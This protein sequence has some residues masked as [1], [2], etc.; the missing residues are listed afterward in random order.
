MRRWSSL[1]LGSLCL[2]LTSAAASPR[3]G[4]LT[5]GKPAVT[6]YDYRSSYVLRGLCDPADPK[7][8]ND[9]RFLLTALRELES[10][11]SHPLASALQAFADEQLA[12]LPATASTGTFFSAG[13]SEEIVG[14]GLKAVVTSSVAGQSPV[15]FEVCVG[16]EA[17][18]TTVGAA[19]ATG[20][21]IQQWKEGA[22]SVVLLAAK[23]LTMSGDTGQ[24]GTYEVCAS[25]AVADPLRPEAAETIAKLRKAGKEVWLCSGDNPVTARAVARQ[26]TSP[27]SALSPTT[28]ADQVFLM[29]LVGI[30]DDCVIA[31]V[32]PE[33]KAE[34]INKLKGMPA[35]VKGST[36]GRFI[37]MAGDGTNDAVA[38]AAADVGFVNL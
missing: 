9:R 2:A 29:R 10:Q 12:L 4:T 18:M 3:T 27:S 22:K 20:P 21:L 31:G 1:W 28:V 11:S 37:L 7:A 25:F 35:L 14:R 24:T 32:L 26:G 16:N 34:H 30:P 13:A 8:A 15:R 6:D 38:L 33:G 19:L 36:I 17:L 23:R 5:T